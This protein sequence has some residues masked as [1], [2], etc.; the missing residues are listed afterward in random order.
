MKAT[1]LENLVFT[2]HFKKILSE[3]GALY[4]FPGTILI[5]LYIT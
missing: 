1:F 5:I 3:M 4:G 2:V